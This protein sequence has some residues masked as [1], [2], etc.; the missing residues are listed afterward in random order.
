MRT[1]CERAR[2]RGPFAAGLG[3]LA[4]AAGPGP[5]P[6]PVGRLGGAPAPL[7]VVYVP[8]VFHDGHHE[9]H[10]GGE[11]GVSWRL[12]FSS[13]VPECGDET[14]FAAVRFSRSTS[15]FIVAMDNKFSCDSVSRLIIRL[16]PF[17]NGLFD[18]GRSRHF[19]IIETDARLK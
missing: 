5:V 8:V 7:G 9:R 18:D 3:H 17:S 12:T 11:D 2:G 6:V 16:G 15:R 4:D 1:E 10:L 13:R 14:V 19:R